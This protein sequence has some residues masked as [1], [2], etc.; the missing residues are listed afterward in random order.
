MKLIKAD[1]KVEETMK[2]EEDGEKS[3]HDKKIDEKKQEFSKSVKGIM[4][5]IVDSPNNKEEVAKDAAKEKKKVVIKDI[6][7]DMKTSIHQYEDT[8]DKIDKG[9]D[10]SGKK[11]QTDRA[12]HDIKD[13]KGTIGKYEHL[14]DLTV[15]ALKEEGKILQHE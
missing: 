7:G 15:N 5:S 14:K 10:V 11:F 2:K 12:E 9:V 4:K 6:L 13:I 8:K 3:L 1:D